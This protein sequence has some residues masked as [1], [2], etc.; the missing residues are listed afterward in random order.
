MSTP[1]SGSD[2]YADSDDL[3][4][5]Y[6]VRSVI[7]LAS[8]DT[9]PIAESD[10][11]TDPRVLACLQDASGMIEAACTVGRRYTPA[12]L[13]ALTGNSAQFLKRLCCDLAMGMLFLARPDRKG[14]PPKAYETALEF[15]KA[16]SHGEWV[17]GLLESQNSGNLSHY[18]E[19]ADD[20]ENRHGLVVAARRF[21]SRRN[22]Q[23]WG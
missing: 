19:T 2:S 8:D 4:A 5:R 11:T 1:S 15:L 21:F 22:N 10:L 6:D 14:D 12:D 17:F 3:I 20:V 18:V 9:T 16:L 7:E 13:A 23:A